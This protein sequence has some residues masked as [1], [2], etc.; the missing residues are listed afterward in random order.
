[1]FQ[2][3][4]THFKVELLVFTLCVSV[5]VGLMVQQMPQAA[6][7]KTTSTNAPA[8]K[9]FLEIVAE[10]NASMD[11]LKGWVIN[12]GKT[13]T[14]AQWTEAYNSY[15]SWRTHCATRLPGWKVPYDMNSLKAQVQ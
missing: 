5:S 7:P 12:K 11:Q 13:F 15:S 14:D 2:W 9:P 10:C 6:I 4:L 1:M 3:L 8:N